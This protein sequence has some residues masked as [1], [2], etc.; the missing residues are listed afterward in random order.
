MKTKSIALFLSL[1]VSA[2]VQAEPAAVREIARKLG[3]CRVVR[4]GDR[5][6]VELEKRT[7]HVARGASTKR[8]FWISNHTED[9]THPIGLDLRSATN[10]TVRG[11]G[12]T[13]VFHDACVGVAIEDA[14]N[15]KLADLKL[16][17]SRPIVTEGEI[18]RFGAGETTVRIDRTHFPCRVEKGGLVA[19]G[20][21]WE[22]RSGLAM[23]FSG[24]THEIVE[25]TDDF[26]VKGAAREN[27]DGTVTFA[28][29]FSAG[30]KV[31]PGDILILRPWS[32]PYPAVFVYHATDTVLEDVAIHMAWGM[33]LIA[34]MSENVTW[35]GTRTA[36]DRTNGC[37][38]PE[39]SKQVVTLHADASHF[40]NVKGRVT[41]EN[42]LFE[43]MMDDAVNVHST[44]LGIVKVAGPKAIRCRYMH[45][46][47]TGFGVF[48]AGDRLRFIRGKTLENDAETKVVSVETHG[49]REVTL[50]L[51][52]PLPAGIAPGDAVENADYQPSVVCRGNVIRNNRARGVLFTTPKPIVC[53]SNVFDHVSGAA[54]L[55]A[56][57]AQGWY[58]SGACADVTVRGNVITDCLTS[59][60][61]Q[62]CGGLIASWPTIREPTAQKRHYHRNLRIEGNVFNTFKVPLLYA[63][64]TDDVVFRGNTVNYN[65]HYAGWGKGAFDVK[66]CARCDLS[67]TGSCRG[68]EGK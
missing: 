20:D 39:G 6:V 50:M 13:V 7:Y 47:A 3:P 26:V 46:Q 35:R 27:A 67:L 65:T 51:A 36:L 32:R 43:T 54:I 34:Q 5:T 52:D 56:G 58:E 48:N 68:D 21:G 9:F 62:F 64:S 31:K 17:W 53:E 63:R 40:S 16:A 1:A 25:T 28:Q 55:F 41:V 42:G 44:C 30:G 57:D 18:V 24:K 38:P 22:Y 23:T 29:D 14:A 45:P 49:P 15:V 2:S 12:A 60:S 61:F 37:F 19:V 33:G 66:D 11:N 4:D 8:D 59:P 10:L